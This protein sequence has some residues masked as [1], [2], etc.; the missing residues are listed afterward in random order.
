MVK[1]VRFLGTM[2][3]SLLPC[4]G[5]SDSLLSQSGVSYLELL[6]FVRA[7][8]AGELTL[9]HSEVL[10][11]PVWQKVRRASNFG[12]GCIVS[13]SRFTNIAAGILPIVSW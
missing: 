5:L 4:M 7:C 6:H 9:A 13:G 3:S 10:L 12:V 8:W 1:I 11:L 2:Y